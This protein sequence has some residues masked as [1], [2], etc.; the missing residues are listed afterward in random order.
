LLVAG[1]DSDAE[2]EN[3]AEFLTWDQEAFSRRAPVSVT[4]T[5]P[6]ADQLTPEP[7][8][9]ATGNNSLLSHSRAYYGRSNSFGAADDSITSPD[10]DNH[11]H[12][13][14]KTVLGSIPQAQLAQH[15]QRTILFT[16]LHEKTTHKDLTG[17]LRGGRLLDIYLR[18]D[19]SATV[20]F[21]EGAA[22]FMNYAKRND[23]YIHNKRVKFA[24]KIVSEVSSCSVK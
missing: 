5:K 12:Y 10:N 23:F 6:I 7:S 1:A 4:I 15:D 18:N 11:A 21:A 14:P 19:R 22:E 20:S 2:L 24:P 13:L 3:S 9:R 17:M 16:N 8:E